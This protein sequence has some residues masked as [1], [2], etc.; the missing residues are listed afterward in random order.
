M[1]SIYQHPYKTLTEVS[2]PFD[3]KNDTIPYY[4]DI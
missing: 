3:F 4:D 1:I 2:T